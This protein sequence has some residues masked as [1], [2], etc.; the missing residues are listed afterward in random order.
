MKL[1]IVTLAALLAAGA[2]GAQAPA[3]DPH[4]GHGA[5]SAATPADFATGEVRRIDREAQKVTLRHGPIP[6]LGMGNMTMV[7]RVAD[8]KLL[9][10]VKQGDTV[11]FKA[12]K[13]GG[14]YTVTALEPAR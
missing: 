3:A 13:L 14:Q 9:D 8:P 12:D 4:A 1:P 5:A 11:R 6:N 7:F 2:A 10:A